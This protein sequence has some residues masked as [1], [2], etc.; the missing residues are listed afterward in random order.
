[1]DPNTSKA[2]TLKIRNKEGLKDLISLLN[3]KFRT[4]KIYKFNSLIDYM[5]LS[6]SY[7]DWLPLD[8]SDFNR[9]SWLSGFS[10]GDAS[11]GIRFTD[12]NNSKNKYDHISLSFEIVQSRIDPILFRT[13][14]EI[15]ISISKFLLSNLSPYKTSKYDRSGKQDAFRSRITSMKGAKVVYDYFTLFPMMNSKHLY[16]LDWSK[17]YNIIIN[18][19]NYRSNNN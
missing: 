19:G 18:K 13:Y 10:S 7:V 8:N 2:F 15:M 1:M 9:N 16:F 12:S 5:N 11:F 4:P 14:E 6:S 3:G 17:C